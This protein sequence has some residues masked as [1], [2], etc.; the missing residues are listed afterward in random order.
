VIDKEDHGDETLDELF[1]LIQPPSPSD[2]DWSELERSGNFVPL[3]FDWYKFVGALANALSF[4]QPAS[5]DFAPISKHAY[6]VLSGLLHRC[7]RLMLANVALSH[8][9]KFGETSSIVDRCLCETAIKIAWLCHSDTER[10]VVQYMADSMKPECEFENQIREHIT[11]RRG[12]PTAIEK[13]MLTSIQRHFDA[14][15][16]TRENAR[17]A[18]RLPDLAT[19]IESVGYERLDYV[20]LQRLGSHHIHG[21]WPSLLMHY[22]ESSDDADSAFVPRGRPCEMHVNQYVHGSRFVLSAVTAYSQRCLVGQSRDAFIGLAD[23]TLEQIIEHFKE[24]IRRDGGGE[25]RGSKG[26][27]P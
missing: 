3:F 8:E 22:I 6:Y 7:A 2:A 1:P 5:R 9:G 24:A 12:R 11:R 14:A 27:L 10:R 17:S 16:I 13:R 21:T 20:I 26:E 19:M 25:F 15:G 18:K 4:V 23:D